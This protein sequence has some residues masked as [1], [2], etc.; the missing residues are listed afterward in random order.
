MIATIFHRYIPGIKGGLQ[1][2]MSDIANMML[3]KPDL[4]EDRFERYAVYAV[5][6]R[7][8]VISHS[9]TLDP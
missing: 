5:R 9:T 7:S 3:R 4:V 6:E 2:K 1:N 8:Q